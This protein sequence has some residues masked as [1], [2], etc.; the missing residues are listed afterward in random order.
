M[1]IFDWITCRRVGKKECAS[2]FCL[3]LL[4]ILAHA[5]ALAQ[6]PGVQAA[7]TPFEATVPGTSVHDIAITGTVQELITAQ[8]PGA[9]GG[10]QLVVEGPQGAFTA[11]L[12][13]MLSD[14]VQ[15]TLSPGTPVQISGVMQTIN[16]K[17]YL[18]ARKLNLA[19]D[20]IIIRNDHGFLV[21][22]QRSSHASLNNSALSGG[23]K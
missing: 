19:G 7:S 21:H 13:S 4:S 16:G 14:Q 18:L 15:Q 8:T 20:Q 1:K 12:G 11:S 6:Q 2:F 22:S 17:S 23:A 3:V 10:I 9:P 5:V